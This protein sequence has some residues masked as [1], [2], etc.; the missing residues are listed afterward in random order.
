MEKTRHTML[1]IPLS[2]MMI[3]RYL[4][5]FLLSPASMD[6]GTYLVYRVTGITASVLRGENRQI[7]FNL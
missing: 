5:Y 2:Q 6:Y 7:A 3:N 4:P 1:G